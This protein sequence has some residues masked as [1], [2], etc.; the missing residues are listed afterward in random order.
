[1]TPSESAGH[2]SSTSQDGAG[3]YVETAESS[4]AWS[5]SDEHFK[6]GGN[7]KSISKSKR[8]KNYLHKK[9]K[10]VANTLGGYS[11]VTKPTDSRHS[12]WYVNNDEDIEGLSS[13]KQNIAIEEEIQDELQEEVEEM[14]DRFSEDVKIQIQRVENVTEV[15]KEDDSVDVV[16][17]N[18]GDSTEIVQQEENELLDSLPASIPVSKS[19]CYKLNT[20]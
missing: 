11:E 6:R 7:N 16:S 8:V 5:S 9:C 2:A 17:E 1:M 13:L 12:S 4:S 18:S 3:K 20:F 14:V 15:T 10:D 19:K